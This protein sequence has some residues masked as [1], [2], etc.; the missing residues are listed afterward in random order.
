MISGKVELNN[1]ITQ[2]GPVW[3]KSFLF[4]L[5]RYSDFIFATSQKFFLDLVYLLKGHC[6]NFTHTCVCLQVLRNT[7][8]RKVV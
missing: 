6:T 7:P 8:V 3:R 4:T 5:Y 2:A 1:T